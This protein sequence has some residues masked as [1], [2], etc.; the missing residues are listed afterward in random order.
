M[1]RASSRALTLLAS[2][3]IPSLAVAATL[4]PIP[5]EPVP[6]EPV[7]YHD[8]VVYQVEPKYQVVA[9]P[10]SYQLDNNYSWETNYSF[11]PYRKYTLAEQDSIIAAEQELTGGTLGIN[12]EGTRV[13]SIGQPIIREA[14]TPTYYPITVIRE[15]VMAQPAAMSTASMTTSSTT[16]FTKSYYRAE[17]FGNSTFGAGYV[18]DASMTATPATSTTAKKV[19]AY[20]DGKVLGTAFGTQKELFRGR[21]EVSGQSGGTNAGTAR[22]YAMQQQIYVT[23][24]Y[25]T[26]SITPINWSRTFFSAS[27]SF[28]VGPVPV[29]VKASLSGGVKLS[30]SGQIGP[31]VAK[32]NVTPGAWANVTAS[33]AVNIIVAKFGI[34]GSVMLINVSIPTVGELFWPYC[35]LDWKLTS[36]LSLNYLSGTLKAFVEVKLIFFNKKWTVTIASWGGFSKNI[37]LINESGSINLGLCPIIIR[38]PIIIQQSPQLVSM[39]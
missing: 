39:N 32:L 22:V 1:S 24:L 6:L 27:K 14:Y 9:Y 36:T 15:P 38:D 10:D 19:Q 7:V 11:S 30:V 35:T 13:L 25:S 12:A 18:I 29:T 8:P 26:F 31:T 23:N 37:T 3:V 20:A 5:M 21:A 4:E 16:P 17:N 28:M 33:A 34:E 2:F